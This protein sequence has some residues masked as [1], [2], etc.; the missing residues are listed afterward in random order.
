M[1]AKNR[2]RASI[3]FYQLVSW[4]FFDTWNPCTLNLWLSETLK[5]SEGEPFCFSKNIVVL[6]NKKNIWKN[7][8]II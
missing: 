5:K 6:K 8:K 4:V 3:F 2:G 7:S 1:I